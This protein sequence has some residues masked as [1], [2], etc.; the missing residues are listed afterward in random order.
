MSVDALERSNT[1]TDVNALCKDVP[2]ATS[3]PTSIPLAAETA[4]ACC[5]SLT[6]TPLGEAEAVDL[7]ATYAAIADPIRLRLLSLIAAS[8]EVCSCDLTAPLGRSQPTVSHHTKLLAEAGL[9]V[10]D[11]RGRWVHWSV[12]PDQVD[13]VQR[14]LGPTAP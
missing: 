4:G 13:F 7:A 9:I 1:S 10:G 5:G 6:E 14:V 2:V 11:R 8:G 3:T 12:H